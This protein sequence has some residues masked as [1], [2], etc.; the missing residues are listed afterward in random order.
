MSFF[1]GSYYK[2][3]KIELKG[4]TIFVTG[5]AGFIGAGLVKQLYSNEE[6]VTVIGIDNMNDYCNLEIIICVVL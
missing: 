5:A 6:S 2:I 4:K 1:I 3:Q